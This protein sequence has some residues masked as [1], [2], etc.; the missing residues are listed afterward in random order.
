MPVLVGT[1]GWQYKHWDRRFYAAS[2]ARGDQLARYAELFAVVEVNATFYRL[3]EAGVFR[4]WAEQ[5]PA[6]FRFVVKASRFLTHFKRLKDPEEPV[7]RL[8][9]R[10]RELGSKLSAVLL[11][12]PPQMH[13]DAGRLDAALALLGKEARVA[14]EPRHES[15]YTPEVR[16]VLERHGAA[17]CLADRGSAWIT[18][19]W[20]TAAWGYLRFH[21]GAVQPPG[22]YSRE[23]LAERASEAAVL[24]GRQAEVFA[25]FN[26]DMHLCALRDA[27]WFAAE[28]ARAGLDPTR[29][30][31]AEEIPVG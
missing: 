17:L 1:S 20:R 7:A 10:A 19:R 25:F 14:V 21:G 9:G 8:M 4:A 29:V 30:P 5:T 12:L 16:E 11:Q 27:G 3:P 2:L 22:C 28:A 23:A 24:W 13:G 15:W 6:D 18:P 31:A 26:N